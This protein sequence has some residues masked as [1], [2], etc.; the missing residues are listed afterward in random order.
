[1]C[2]VDLKFGLVFSIHED[3]KATE[4]LLCSQRS[5]MCVILALQR[6]ISKNPVFDGAN[7]EIFIFSFFFFGNGLIRQLSWI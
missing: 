2:V 7:R 3:F 4:A 6:K 5:E 1:M